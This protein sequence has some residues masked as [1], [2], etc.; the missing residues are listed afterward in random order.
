MSASA[1]GAVLGL[2]VGLGLLLVV[3]RLRAT[4]R[5]PLVA[6]VTPFV[7]GRHSLAVPA[8]DASFLGA[9]MRPTPGAG[10][11]RS[12]SDTLAR[13][14]R[15]G[16]LDRFRVE[17]VAGGLIGAVAGGGLGLL[18]MLRG[19]PLISILLLAA[20][21][22][23]LGVL[24]VDR[25]LAQRARQ[26]SARMGRELPAVAELLAFA[27]AAGE[28][29][30]AALER[31]T[32]LARGEFAGE[33]RT[34]VGEMRA[35]MPMDAALRGIADRSGNGD[36]ERFVDGIIV[37]IERGTPLVDVLRAQAADARAA[38]RR[39]LLESAGRKDVTMLVPVVFFILPT[40]IAIALFPGMQSLQLVV[41]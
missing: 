35:G 8:D 7:V 18:A 25:Q 37:A 17:Q 21:G 26:R 38:Q 39:A 6:R 5:L 15:M 12:L 23:V 14:G 10:S 40:V 2:V 27:V 24:V 3:S 41:P 29:P 16:D 33:C 36:V 1:V 34:A 20:F 11:A 28:S 9:L 22:A 32:A 13:A 4:R 19:G 31:V 30:M